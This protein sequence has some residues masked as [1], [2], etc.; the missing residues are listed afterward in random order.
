[1][2][3]ELCAASTPPFASIKEVPALLAEESPQLPEALP[4]STCA[5]FRRHALSRSDRGKKHTTK[6]QPKGNCAYYGTPSTPQAC[7]PG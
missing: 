2:T 7:L 4:W 5:I 3:W 6:A 1:M